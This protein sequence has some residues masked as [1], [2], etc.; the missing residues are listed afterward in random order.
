MKQYNGKESYENT[1]GRFKE[2]IKKIAG[3]EYVVTIQEFREMMKYGERYQD[4]YRLKYQINRL[5]KDI[6]A[7]KE[8]FIN[9][10]IFNYED[11]TITLYAEIIKPDIEKEIEKEQ[12]ELNE[13]IERE[14]P[15]LSL[16]EYEMTYTLICKGKFGGLVFEYV[17]SHSC[18][19]YNETDADKLFQNYM[20]RELKKYRVKGNKSIKYTYFVSSKKPVEPYK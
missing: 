4:K 5:V 3:K 1:L 8:Y 10:P 2:I 13:K 19:A 12:K 11:N 14:A 17:G 6:N 18:K 20:D 7:Q 9:E 16:Y 15:K